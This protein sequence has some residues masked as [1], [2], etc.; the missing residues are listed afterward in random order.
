MSVPTSD[1][2]RVDWSECFGSLSWSN[3][4]L[5][6]CNGVMDSAR[7]LD[8]LGESVLQ[9]RVSVCTL[10]LLGFFSVSSDSLIFVL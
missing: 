4:C 9:V 5:G 6:W 2:S 7:Y 1:D 10:A 8:L 3:L